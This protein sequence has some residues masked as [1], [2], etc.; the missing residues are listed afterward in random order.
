MTSWGA[1]IASQHGRNTEPFPPRY[2]RRV[3]VLAI[4]GS[5]NAKSRNLALLEAVVAAAPPDMVI[6]VSDHLRTLPHF[7]PDFD[8]TPPAE[9]VAWRKALAESDAVLIAAPE[10]AHIDPR[11]AHGSAYGMVPAARGFLRRPGVWNFEQVTVKGSRVAV[12]LNGTQILDTDLSKVTEFMDG[13]THP[14]KDRTS[15]HFGFAGHND[16]VAYR[17]ISI[18]ELK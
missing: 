4:C 12:E 11:Q 18:K 17:K 5:L 16:P 2:V 1:A 14:G 7:D 9:V 10:Y 3:N 15:G 8:S 13:K 6:T